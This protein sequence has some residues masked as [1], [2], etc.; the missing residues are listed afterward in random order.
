MDFL[1]TTRQALREAWGCS[2]SALDL[3]AE[4][5]GRRCYRADADAGPL[6]VKVQDSGADGG[7][8]ILAGLRVQRY[9]RSRNMPVSEPLLTKDGRDHAQTEG[10]LYTAERWLEPEARATG[11]EQWREL[12]ELCGRLHR[13]PATDEIGDLVS[14]LDPGKTLDAVRQR[15]APYRAAV[16]AEYRA[17]LAA[18]LDEATALDHMEG[19]PRVL[20]HSDLTWDNVVRHRG[21]LH[22]IDLEGAGTAPAVMDLA[23]V[24]TKLCRGHSASGPLDEDAAR[25]FYRGYLKHRRLADAEIAAL[26]AAHFFQEIYYLENSLGRGDFDFLNRMGARLQN[27]R[28]GAFEF[29]AAAAAGRA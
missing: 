14:R 6:F 5:H 26:P 15:L 18:C 4:K 17:A 28:G 1:R 8:D 2:V 3:V 7:E 11:P 10:R 19:L 13:L 27:W 9:L 16:P 20:I 25:A 24:T 12:G 29:L 22:L 21:V 23:E